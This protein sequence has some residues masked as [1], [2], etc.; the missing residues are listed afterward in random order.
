MKKMNLDLNKKR[1][2]CCKIEDNIAWDM[3]GY[4]FCLICDEEAIE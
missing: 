1:S 4:F 2:K 3:S